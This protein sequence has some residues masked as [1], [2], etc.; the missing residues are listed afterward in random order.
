MAL[1]HY[2]AINMRPLTYH[3]S[4]CLIAIDSKKENNRRS[5]SFVLCYFCAYRVIVEFTRRK[6][7]KYI[8]LVMDTYAK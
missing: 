5:S 7:A 3:L 8:Y 1:F 4:I 2:L 6:E